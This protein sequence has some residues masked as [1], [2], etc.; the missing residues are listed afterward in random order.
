MVFNL[1]AACLGEKGAAAKACP[2]ALAELQAMRLAAAGAPGGGGLLIPKGSGMSGL[3]EVACKMSHS[4]I[5][6][7][8]CETYPDSRLPSHLWPPPVL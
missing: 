8:N 4:C 3:Y 1:N 5:P 7:C 6:S 2:Q